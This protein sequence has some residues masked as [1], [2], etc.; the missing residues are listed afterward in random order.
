MFL[1]CEVFFVFSIP[2]CPECA[3]FIAFSRR[4]A[5]RT[6]LFWR[7]TTPNVVNVRRSRWRLNFSSC[8]GMS[9]QRL[10]LMTFAGALSSSSLNMKWAWN[11]KWNSRI[12]P[13]CCITASLL[14]QLR[15]GGGINIVGCVAPPWCLTLHSCRKY[16]SLTWGGLA[17]GWD[18]TMGYWTMKLKDD[19][20]LW[21]FSYEEDLRVFRCPYDRQRLSLNL[22]LSSLH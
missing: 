3:I 12:I 17:E 2:R 1:I 21:L 11:T 9:C 22:R 10:N 4:A 13:T 18:V 16:V 19:G 14:F 5:D 7:R 15:P 20:L 8:S 6:I